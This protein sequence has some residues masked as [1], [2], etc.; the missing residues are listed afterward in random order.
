[1]QVLLDEGLDPNTPTSD[2]AAILPLH[3]CTHVEVCRLLLER[4]ALLNAHDGAGQTALQA[5]LGRGDVDVAS[6][7][8]ERGADRGALAA[9]TSLNVENQFRQ[10][11]P[12]WI[13]TLPALKSLFCIAGNPLNS[14]P[15]YI[16]SQGNDAV[17][18][19][20]QDIA[21]S[22]K[23]AVWKRVKVM[24]LGKEGVGKTHIRH[25]VSGK[26]YLRNESTDGIEIK[27]FEL[28]SGMSVKWFDF[29]G[30]EIFY[31]THQFFLTPQCVYLVVF[32]LTDPDYEQR[33][34][35]WLKVVQSIMEKSQQIKIVVIGTHLDKVKSGQEEKLKASLQRLLAKHS[36]VMAHVFVSCIEDQ[37]KVAEKIS[38]GIELAAQESGLVERE[39]PKSYLAVCQ[40]VREKEKVGVSR[41][42]WEEMLSNFP[43]LNELFLERA[44]AFLHNMGDVF[45]SKAQGV[46]C[47]DVR[48][49]ANLFSSLVT[50]RHRWVKDG[51]LK[52]ED[53]CHIWVDVQKDEIGNILSLFQDFHVA[54]RRRKDNVW[55]VPSLLPQEAVNNMEEFFRSTRLTQK[56]LYKLSIVPFGVFGRMIARVQEWKDIEILSMWRNGIIYTDIAKIAKLSCSDSTIV[57]EIRQRKKSTQKDSGS[58]LRKTDAELNSLFNTVFHKTWSTPVSCSLVCPHCLGNNE[59]EPSILPYN[60][61]VDWVLTGVK[62]FPCSNADE[63][64]LVATLGDDLSFEYVELVRQ[65]SI[66]LEERAFAKGGFG[67]IFKGVMHRQEVV[68]KQIRMTSD[69]NSAAMFAEFQHEVSVM[70][71]FE[72]V[73]LVRLLGIMYCPLRMVLEYCD[74]GDLLHALRAHQVSKTRLRLRIASDV[75]HGMRYLH[76]LDP[77]LAHRDLRSPNIF[78]CSLDADKLCAKVADFGLAVNVS[79]FVSEP[80]LTWQWMAPEAYLGQEYDES[81][82]SYSFGVVLWELLAN[83]GVIPFQEYADKGMQVHEVVRMVCQEALRPSVLPSFQPAVL[84]KLAQQLWVREPRNRPDFDYCCTVIDQQFQGEHKPVPPQ[85]KLRHKLAPRRA[86]AQPPSLPSFPYEARWSDGAGDDVACIWGT[87]YKGRETLWKGGNEGSVTAVVGQMKVLDR[88]HSH[89][90]ARVTA[91][92]SHADSVWSAADDGSLVKH[93]I[94]SSMGTRKP[95]PTPS[96]RH[97]ASNLSS[98]GSATPPPRPVKATSSTSLSLSL[99]RN[100]RERESNRSPRRNAFMERSKESVSPRDTNN[101]S[102]RTSGI[103][104]GNARS[105]ARANV[106]KMASSANPH[107]D[108]AILCAVSFGSYVVTG[109]SAGALC[110]WEDFGKLAHQTSSQ[111]NL[112]ITSMVADD[113]RCWL[114]CF[115][116]IYSFSCDA[117]DKLVLFGC[118]VSD[119]KVFQLVLVGED[120]LYSACRSGVIIWNCKG[121]RGDMVSQVSLVNVLFSLAVVNFHG[122]QV[123]VGG[124]KNELNIMS[125]VNLQSL[126]KILDVEGDIVSIVGTLQ[127]SVILLIRTESGSKVKVLEF[128]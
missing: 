118:H 45:F 103:V 34:K 73:N 115:N 76:S 128:L 65:E 46:L 67:D 107:T 58:L 108:N 74:K 105:S 4:G 27:E 126:R 90:N 75:A 122:L 123:V 28:K 110:V 111:N 20:L 94:S 1:M 6:L 38:R 102:P 36:S 33:V 83:T 25:L 104:F 85:R 43:G 39:V 92:V 18:Q 47:F 109:D 82:D 80:L 42:G 41:M 60:K 57:L 50:F 22:G 55:V 31:P 121:A 7:L 95:V 56:R 127:D 91:F 11:L 63:P 68:V 62:S 112:P 88:T 71:Q 52:K 48:W 69:D 19:Y 9:V 119:D 117:L 30:Q 32:S 24:V 29:G 16:V 100:S 89:S 5:A 8:L 12:A 93:T 113:S 78:L 64:I 116:D 72:H 10:G 124:S 13:G 96:P 79:T 49:L 51:I 15:S 54:F 35:Y 53:M 114:S 17:L 125:P 26:K 37:D 81:C 84:V 3:L 44:F 120:R 66:R 23:K 98:S 87:H 86:Q 70:G 77:P 21:S 106:N 14:I 99:G 59:A 61:C 2:K 40:W 97:S 101:V